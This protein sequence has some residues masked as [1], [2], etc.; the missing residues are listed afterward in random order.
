ME[1]K[2]GGK[3]PSPPAA[4]IQIKFTIRS[5]KPFSPTTTLSL[6]VIDFGKM[7]TKSIAGTA[8]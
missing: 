6:P 3:R 1:R 5:A 2:K 8:A 4:L 7:D